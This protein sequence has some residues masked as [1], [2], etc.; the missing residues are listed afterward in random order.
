ML[1]STY[2]KKR[3][4]DARFLDFLLKR[5]AVNDCILEFPGTFSLQGRQSVVSRLVLI[6][7]LVELLFKFLNE[8]CTPALLLADILKFLHRL[9][10]DHLKLL[11]I[12]LQSTDGGSSPRE[13]LAGRLELIDC[14]IHL[15]R[16]R[17]ALFYQRLDMSLNLTD[18]CFLSENS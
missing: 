18:V 7:V 6:P 5:L 17:L 9:R 13:L 14:M 1:T 10:I 8:S 12:A 15:G 3:N 16:D 4:L 11:Q 2:L